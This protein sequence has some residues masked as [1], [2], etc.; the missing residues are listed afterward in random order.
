M[1]YLVLVL[2]LFSIP[3]ASGSSECRTLFI[4]KMHGIIKAPEKINLQYQ[5]FIEHLGL[6]ESSNNWR[7]VNP[8]GMMGK[9]QFSAKT[10]ED[11]GY[12]GITPA[13][14]KADPNIFPVAMQERA[15]KDLIAKNLHSLTKFTQYIGQVVNG[16][17]IT[18]AGL[19]AAS[20]LA[21]VGGVQR[22][23]TSNHNATD[24]NG[25]SVQHY[26]QEFQAYTV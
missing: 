23:L 8:I 15:L 26:L 10:L 18:R 6:V 21:G 24:M 16:V 1:K 7:V 14:F 20:H 9:Y 17:L 2:L 3:L 11:L 13:R 19:V 5:S 12:H 22:Y 4:A 25:S